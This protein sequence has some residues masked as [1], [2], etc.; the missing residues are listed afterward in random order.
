MKNKEK[1]PDPRKSRRKF[2]KT[3]G[4]SFAGLSVLPS[5]IPAFGSNPDAAGISDIVLPDG[6]KAVW[7]ISKAW[8]ET[9]TTRERIC[10]NGLWNWQPGTLEAD[11]LPTDD[12]G[13]F[14]V[15]GNWPGTRNYTLQDN[16]RVFT[17]PSWE[18]RAV[19]TINAAWYQ[20]EISIP[21]NWKNR[22]ILLTVDYINSRALVL[23]DGKKAGELLFP[24]GELDITPMVSPG[25][26]YVLSMKVTALPQ[27]DV[28]A[29]Y[30]DSNSS[31]LGKGVVARKG[32]CGDVYLFSIPLKARLNEVRVA[33]YVRKREIT[34]KIGAE[35]LSPGSKYSFRAVV[36][37]KGNP[38]ITFTSDAFAA[39]DL[40]DGYFSFTKSWL[41]DK[42]WDTHTPENMFD[43][44][45]SLVEDNGKLADT[46]L[47]VRFGFREFWID[48]RDFYLNGSRIYLSTV[49]FDNAQYGAALSTY[50]GAR[51]SMLRLKSFGINFVYTHN[52]GCEPGTHLG[53]GEILRAADDAG[54]LF[55]FSLPHFG[56]YDWTTPEAD[57]T[58][59]YAHHAAFYI[60]EAQNHPAIV[61]YSM[62]HNGTGYADDM[63]PD[64]IDGLIRP[65]SA[66]ASPNV[67]KALR[68]EAIAT[69]LDPT[70][71]VYH[72]SSGNL[73]SMHTSN[74]YPNW[75]PVQ[76]MNDWFGHWAKK[77]VKPV[78]LCEYGLP[79]TWDWSMYR[80]W[81]KGKREFGS[82]K[83][84]WEFCL[85]EWNAQFLGDKAYLISEK[86]KSNLR[87]EADKFRK[88][89]LWQRWDYPFDLN[90]R[91]LEERN[92]VFAMHIAENWRAFRTWGMSANS[93]WSHGPYW[94]L[95]QGS[96]TGR[97]DFKVDWENIQRPGFSPD[98]L[99]ARA[100]RRD[101]D[102]FFNECDWVPNEGGE[103]LLRNNMPLLACIGG[104]PSSITSKDHNFDAGTTF[105]K[106]LIIINNTRE[107]VT[108]E[109][110]WT[111]NL[112]QKIN[113][114]KALSIKTGQQ[115]LVP[116]RFDL[117]SSLA[118]GSYEI[119]SSVKFS[120]G[121]TQDDS[122][123]IHILPATVPLKIRS[124]T[125]LFDP[126]GE[127]AK[128]LDGLGINYQVVNEG[129]ALSGYDLVI[130][131]KEALTLEGQGLDL[132]GVRDGLKVVV[133]EQTSEVLEKR[134]GFRVQEYG[135]R[136]VYKRISDHPVLSGIGN[137]NLRDWLGEST[138]L[139]PKL[140]YDPKIKKFGNGVPTVEWCGIPVTRLWRC[141]NKGNVA[142]V[143][144]EK[145]AC[146]NFLPL[147][148]GGY[149]LQY[150]PLMEYRE[151][152]GMV[153]F[154]Q[155]DVTGRTEKEPVCGRLVG[156][157]VSYVATWKPV[158]KLKPVYAGESAGMSHLEKAGV[159]AMPLGDRKLTSKDILIAGPGSSEALKSNAQVKKWISAGGRVLA[160]GLS[161]EEANAF[162][163][164]GVTMKNEEH[165][166]S[167]F[168]TL[169]VASPFAGA[170]PSDVH[171]RAPKQ[172]PLVSEGASVVGNG[173]L[174]EKDNVVFCQLVPWQM[175]YSNEQ[176]NVKQTFRRSSYLLSRIMGNMEVESTTPITDR[177]NKPAGKEEK[178]WLD[179][180]YL[181]QPEEWDDPYRF[182]RW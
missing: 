10:I 102:S 87:W 98:F 86:E 15:P 126:K 141:G 27:S 40:K 125:A 6:V 127:T 96:A 133:F 128:F 20:R 129:S 72:H 46:A 65:E 93:P 33:T 158:K 149:S 48:G 44:S 145:P 24:S 182:F 148:D 37:E 111:L 75:V 144:I 2:I 112:P 105:E 18:G 79:F 118:A 103:A 142:S 154:C 152:K 100:T 92:T 26:K 50:E 94:K 68:S 134:F 85:A 124:K 139:P 113:G 119:K 177:F 138:I 31:K 122:F 62:S 59:G 34:L 45:V 47:P 173:V 55:S 91:E 5:S 4:M 114:S 19:N 63:N 151:G 155:M 70:R 83:V 179:G 146:G 107:S 137:D 23:I 58:N 167:Y 35:N 67:K 140:K 36:S 90:S 104:K 25:K 53:F 9:T 131:G 164:S 43:L 30:N 12:W 170:G 99:I 81:Y 121:E 71:I 69:A 88:G 95:R 76:E 74:F 150:S 22:N 135:L 161:N 32:L 64:M 3:T 169:S 147:A 156:N 54:M 66:W 49:P 17:Q 51:E 7:D 77:G 73:S 42:L 1:R 120:N 16:Q 56:Q 61:F 172:L 166:A 109:C 21:E 84:P 176:H 180:L 52:Y 163:P 80:G 29:L 14:K 28:V 157:L 106:Q 136:Q 178:R 116:M 110:N 160:V 60:R 181:D 123:S 13:Y 38:V 159:A 165:I 78:F 39:G 171:N 41:P 132:T 57:K 174:A 117:P 82:A 101:M 143:L 97:K 130:V 175:D 108:C 115:E 89:E 168:D 11:Q 162:L 8:H 153:I